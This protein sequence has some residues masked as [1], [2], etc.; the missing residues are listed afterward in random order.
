MA[1]GLDPDK[2]APQLDYGG[3][4]KLEELLR[5]QQPLS[6]PAHHDEL[7]F[8]VIHQIYELWF[9][10]ILHE[11]DTVVER[12]DADDPLEA[13][14]LLRRCI[15]IQRVLIAQ[16]GV[17]ETMT[18]NDFLKFR[19][20]LRPASGFQS[21]QFRGVEYR[22]GIKN[23]GHIKQFEEH[24]ELKRMLERRMDEPTL[25]DAFWSLLER[26]DFDTSAGDDADETRARRVRAL[27]QVYEGAR[28][29]RDLYLLAEALIEY[30]EMFTVWRVRHV[31][32]AERMIGAKPGTGGSEGVGYLRR[33]IEHRFFPELWEVRS[34]LGETDGY[35]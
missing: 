21:A 24:E 4:L 13:Q 6:E 26:R 18:P 35:G 32:M 5:L 16:I 17:L 9:K 22:S 20:H 29:Y 2:G 1:F 7:L 14:R 23:R 31:G 10:Q 27:V 15:E 30:D 12:M 8:I 25:L 3:Y 19:D 28:E 11:V 33:T 34:H